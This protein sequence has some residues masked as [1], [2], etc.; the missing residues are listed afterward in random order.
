[1]DRVK[2]LDLVDA[3]GIRI[4]EDTPGVDKAL[5]GGWDVFEVGAG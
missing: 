4:L 2:I 3:Q 5:V 1:M